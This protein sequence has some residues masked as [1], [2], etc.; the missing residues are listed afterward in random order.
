MSE[1]ELFSHPEYDEHKYL[2]FVADD[3]VGLRAIIAIHHPGDTFAAGGIRMQSYATTGAAL[4]DVLRLSR[5]MTYKLAAAKLPVG[6]AKS[7]IIGDPATQKSP[8][9]LAS[10]ARAVNNLGGSYHCGADVGTNSAD[11]REMSKTSPYT[12]PSDLGDFSIPTAVGVFNALRGAVYFRQRRESLEGIR[13]AV[14]GLGQVGSHLC[15]LLH[16][17]GCELVVCDIDRARSEAVREQTGARIVS[18]DEVVAA[19]VDVFSPCALGGV[20][21]EDT[22][23]KLKATI[24]CGAANNQ[25]ASAEIS[26]LLR[27]LAITYVPDFIANSGGVISGLQRDCGYS[28]S[29]SQERIASIFNTVLRLMLIAEETGVSSVLAA[30]RLARDYLEGRS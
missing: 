3:S 26:A 11:L 14:Q 5:A 2:G 19:E 22:V 6:G 20:L 8:E 1:F 15:T 30:E 25:L 13:V 23:P 7:V 18:C 16:D 29:E 24:V 12:P 17:A 10:F 4:T 9:L 28:D 21:S 27:K